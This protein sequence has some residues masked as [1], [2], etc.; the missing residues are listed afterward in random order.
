MNFRSDRSNRDERRDK[1]P[2]I[3]THRTNNEVQELHNSAVNITSRH[4]LLL[5]RSLNCSA[6]NLAYFVRAVLDVENM[7][8]NNFNTFLRRREDT[9]NS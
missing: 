4:S 7:L 5:Q 6:L 8:T 9:T 1:L 2:F 3:R